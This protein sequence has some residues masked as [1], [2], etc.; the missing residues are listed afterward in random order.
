MKVLLIY[1]PIRTEE[2]YAKYSEGAPCL[3]PLGICYLAKYLLKANY[4]VKIIDCVVERLTLD[5]LKK[6]ILDYAPD[7][8]GISSTTVAFYHAKQVISLVKDIAPQI[9]T[10]L[11][12]AHITA[13]QDETMNECEDI[14]IGVIG[15]GEETLLEVLKKIQDNESLA[16]VLGTIYRDNGN[17]I[18]NERRPVIRDLDVVPFPARELLPHLSSYSHTALRG[19]KGKLTATLITSRGCPFGCR[20]CDQS[21]FGKKWR[22]HSADYVF[23]EIK[24][25]KEKFGVEFISIE[26]DIFTLY[27]PRVMEI[28]QKIIDHKLDIKWACSARINTLDDNVLALMKRAGCQS[29]YV[30]LESG[31]TRILKLIN[32]GIT[33]EEAKEGIIRIRK[34]GINVVA[35]FILGIPSETREEMNQTVKFALSLPVD[36]A[37]FFL[38]TPYPN[39]ELRVLALENGKVST[40]W[41]DYSG[42]P[43]SLPYIPNNMTQDELLDFQAKAYKKFLLR[44]S[45]ICRYIVNNSFL[46]V[47]QKG[48]S[49]IRAFYLRRKYI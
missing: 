10:I 21:I 1:P 31:N 45:F 37:S 13:C 15:E 41:R 3:P 6:R 14:D 42:H 36:G 47:L 5:E 9:I 2:V 49:F 12:G 28:C 20:Y 25:L 46:D 24:T 27:K 33:S 38:F 22:K 11:G 35:S 19:K 29:I 7:I 34:A 44:P 8:A 4:E 40:D 39:T 18:K 48:F 17:I 32:K 43:S 26:D 30:G 16:G 23:S